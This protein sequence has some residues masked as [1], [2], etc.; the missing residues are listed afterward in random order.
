LSVAAIII[1]PAGIPPPGVQANFVD[2]PTNSQPFIVVNCIF[3][4]LAL[5]AIV[6]QIY[7]RLV[8]PRTFSIDDC[9]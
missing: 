1:I 7:S 3:P 4:F 2:P 5:V 9:E 6:V 8:I